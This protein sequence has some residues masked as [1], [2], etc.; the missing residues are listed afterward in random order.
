VPVA[1]PG[2]ARV[3]VLENFVDGVNTEPPVPGGKN[4]D[5]MPKDMQQFLMN[6]ESLGRN[7]EF[8]LYQRHFESEPLGLLR[9]SSVA[10]KPLIAAL[11][12]QF[13]GFGTPEQSEIVINR[14][15]YWIKDTKYDITSHTAIRE[16]K[17]DIDYVIRKQFPIIKFLTERLLSNL[18]ACERI[19]VYQHKHLPP[20]LMLELSDAI[21]AY[22]PNLLLCVREAD[23]ENAAGSITLT[24]PGLMVG[25][26]DREGKPGPSGW[27]I[28]IE[29]WTKF[30]LAAH[31]KWQDLG[32]G[33]ANRATESR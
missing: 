5:P 16:V 17:A 13:E 26:I 20:D 25:Y 9:W 6:F 10:A 4:A 11:R 18:R 15:E 30:C 23:N 8:G 2:V 22:G 3:I 29:I 27:D 24:N 31:Q 28:S 7:C 12:A 33:L 32:H 19:F 1:K 14:G 21:S